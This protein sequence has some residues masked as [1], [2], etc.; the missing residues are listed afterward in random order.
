MLIKK[1]NLSIAIFL[2]L[3]FCQIVFAADKNDYYPLIEGTQWTYQVT[4]FEE[5]N[6]TFEQIVTID[7]PDNFDHYFYSVLRQKDKRGTLRSF[8]LKN[9]KG[10]FWKK[11]GAKKSLGPEVS[12]IFTPEIPIMIFPIGKGKK[13]DWEGNLKIAWINKHIKMRCE[14]MED[15]EEITVPAGRFTCVKI[16]I[17]QLRDNEVS[18]EYGWYSPGIGQI[19]YQTK[20]TLKVLTSYNLK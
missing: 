19:K 17:H 12:S 14:I 8:V 7:K 13:W 16:H 15:N 1:I 10:I 11:I 4:N 3:I 18:D 2:T 5:N 9:E 20:R 6:D